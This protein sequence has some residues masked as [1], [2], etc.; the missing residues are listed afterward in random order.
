M[1]E[2]DDQL[3]EDLRVPVGGFSVSTQLK[4][5]L[6]GVKKLLE[7][8]YSKF[9]EKKAYRL[10]KIPDAAYFI[11]YIAVCPNSGLP[12][13]LGFTVTTTG[14]APQAMLLKDLKPEEVFF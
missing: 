4:A 3:A 2:K 9:K 8:D 6:S 14:Y 13:A 1:A 10:K 7:T 12:M 11:N 5:Q